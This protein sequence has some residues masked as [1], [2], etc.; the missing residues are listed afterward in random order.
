MIQNIII[1]FS[2]NRQTE[3]RNKLVNSFTYLPYSNFILRDTSEYIV[4]VGEYTAAFGSVISNILKL[5]SEGLVF[6]FII[7]FLFTIN[8]LILVYL[9]FIFAIVI[10]FFRILFKQKLNI[11][12]ELTAEGS[13]EMF[14]GINEFFYGFKELMILRNFSYFQNNIMEGARKFAQNNRN[15]Q[16]INILPRY[17]LEVAIVLFI[18]SVAYFSSDVVG[19]LPVISIFIVAAVR[20]MPSVAVFITA[21]NYLVFS[22]YATSKI[23]NEI[24]SIDNLREDYKNTLD[25][26]NNISLEFLSFNMKNV[27]FSYKGTSKKI[28][29]NINFNFDKGDFVGIIGGSGGGKTTLIDVILYLLEPDQGKIEI[30]GNELNSKN[31][32]SWRS[33]TAYLPQDVFIINNTIEANIALGVNKK[34]INNEQYNYAIKKSKIYDFIQSLKLK[35]NTIVG[36]RGIKLSGGQK[37]RIAIA[38]AFYLQRDILIFDESTNALDE[39]NEKNIIDHISSFQGDKTLLLISHKPSLLNRCNKIFEIKNNK[40]IKIK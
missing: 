7:I 15:A 33:I 10:I 18:V 30:N 32:D 9:L 6:I 16:L 36:E 22:R 24:Q 19:M 11:Y 17:T 3:I 31:L 34:N 23:F 38:R 1:T 28:L 39:T 35:D 4:A 14:Q 25:N 20:L 8:G 21:I 5:A 27:N 2:Y 37:Q 40:L 13:R 12:G 29:N 26:K